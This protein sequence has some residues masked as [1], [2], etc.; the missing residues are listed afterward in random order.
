MQQSIYASNGARTTVFV[1]CHDYLDTLL[2][3]LAFLGA[4]IPPPKPELGVM[5]S[6]GR[7]YVNIAWWA[8]AVPGLTMLLVILVVLLT[9][10]YLLQRGSV[11]SPNT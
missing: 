9:S 4:G 10:A 6:E 1:D 3:Y 5:V 8:G 2:A 7:N 11:A